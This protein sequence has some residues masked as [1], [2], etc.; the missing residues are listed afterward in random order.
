LRLPNKE[1]PIRDSQEH[2]LFRAIAPGLPARELLIRDSEE[3]VSFRALALD[4][5]IG[6]S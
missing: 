2:V 5:L 1:L 4:T 3:H 6:S